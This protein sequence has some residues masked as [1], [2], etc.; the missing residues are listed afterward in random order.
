MINYP[1]EVAILLIRGYSHTLQFPVR[2]GS[3]GSTVRKLIE[4]LRANVRS[5]DRVEYKRGKL[6]VTRNPRG[7]ISWNMGKYAG[8]LG[9]ESHDELNIEDL[10]GIIT[11]ELGKNNWTVTGE[12][13]VLKI[14][15]FQK[16]YKRLKNFQIQ[17]QVY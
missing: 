3:T 8:V 16:Y 4:N 7:F 11:K 10:E 14:Q 12:P 13:T 5:V 9:N 1:Y 6:Y 15:Y 17:D 2:K